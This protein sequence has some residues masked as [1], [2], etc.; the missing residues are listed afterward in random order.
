MKDV[1]SAFRGR[2][3]RVRLKGWSDDSSL[4]RVKGLVRLAVHGE[5]EYDDNVLIEMTKGDAVRLARYLLDE[6]TRRDR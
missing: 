3:K 4:P 2:Y 6:A 1:Y 5:S